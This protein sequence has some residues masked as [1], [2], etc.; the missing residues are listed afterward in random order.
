MSTKSNLTL[1]Y[2]AD[3]SRTESVGGRTQNLGVTLTKV[4]QEATNRLS[5][6]ELYPHID[7]LSS[8]GLAV[9]L[10]LLNEA[11]SLLDSAV[12][13]IRSNDAMSADD[14]VIKAQSILP[15]LFRLRLLGDGLSLCVSS[16]YNSIENL[17]GS[18]PS[19][20]QILAMAYVVRIARKNIFCTFDAAVDIVEKLQSADLI[21]EPA[22]L[23]VLTESLNDEILPRHNNLG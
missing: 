23:A 14:L 2:S 6:E 21:I 11:D 3:A 19:E 10:R 20:G 7:E 12:Q 16:L 5:T 8:D 15:D 13:A 4:S 1:A 18:Q 22:S 17:Y 9:A